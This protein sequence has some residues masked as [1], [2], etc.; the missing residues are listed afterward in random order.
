MALLANLDMNDEIWQFSF[1]GRYLSHLHI[2]KEMSFFHIRGDWCLAPNCTPLTFSSDRLITTDSAQIQQ[3]G[4][5]GKSINTKA[6]LPFVRQHIATTIRDTI[7]CQFYKILSVIQ[8][9]I[10]TYLVYLYFQYVSTTITLPLPPGPDKF[11]SESQLIN[12]FVSCVPSIKS[13]LNHFKP[14][15]VDFSSRCRLQSLYLLN[16]NSKF[17]VI[18]LVKHTSIS[19]YNAKSLSYEMLIFWNNEKVLWCNK[20]K[21]LVVIARNVVKTE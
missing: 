2:L 9:D 11:L 1:Q 21:W 12:I 8:Q 15:T 17:L 13:K 4:A 20:I 3:V 7:C 10:F 14:T 16:T 19:C 6:G 18:Y 5:D